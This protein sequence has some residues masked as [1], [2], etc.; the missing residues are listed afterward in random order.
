MVSAYAGFAWGI[1]PAGNARADAKKQVEMKTMPTA[2][3]TNIQGYSIHDGPGIRTVVFLKGCSL[4]CQWCANPESIAPQVQIGFIKNLCTGCGKCFAVCPEDA[5][6]NDPAKNRIDYSKCTACGKCVEVC[7]YK[8][9]VR[10]G[11]PMTVEEVFDAVRRDKMFYDSSGGGITVS[12]GEPL[13]QATFVKELFD[14][15][16]AEGISTCIETA[17]FV[18]PE[19]FKLVLPVTDCILFDLKHMNPDIH[20]KYIG[21]CNERIL[22][23]AKLVAGSGANVLFRIPLIPTINDTD[24]N[25]KQTAAF[26]KSIMKNPKIQLMPYHRMG[27]S[28]Y[29]A[30]KIP[31]LLRDCKVMERDAIEKVRQAYE[32]EGIECTISK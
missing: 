28:K 31:N 16:K 23:N 27:D 11:N 9:M 14:L 30:L 18:S 22:E 6:S 25:I 24:E 7:A 26:V 20:F 21:Q 29:Q 1:R 13:L 3:V 17:G 19:S 12:G 8:A 10:Y 15:C 4:A 2:L 5:L 32:T